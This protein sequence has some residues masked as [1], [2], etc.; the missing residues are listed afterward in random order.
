[1]NETLPSDAERMFQYW[2]RELSATSFQ[3][4]GLYDKDRPKPPETEIR[5]SEAVEV[6]LGRHES[7][8]PHKGILMKLA[9]ENCP[10]RADEEKWAAVRKPR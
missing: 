3:V 2:L 6:F 4:T 10:I 1:M 8:R 9:E 7:F 5:S